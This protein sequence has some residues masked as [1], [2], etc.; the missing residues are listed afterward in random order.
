MYAPISIL[1]TFH[2]FSTCPST[3]STVQYIIYLCTLG[4]NGL[5]VQCC[6]YLQFMKRKKQIAMYCTMYIGFAMFSKS[7]VKACGWK[8]INISTQL[9]GK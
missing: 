7:I 4:T 9:Y 2:S 8:K 5:N 6:Q 3:S 1:L